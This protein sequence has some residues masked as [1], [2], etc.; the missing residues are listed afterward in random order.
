MHSKPTKWYYSR[1]QMVDKKCGYNTQIHIFQQCRLKKKIMES[2]KAHRHLNP[3]KYQFTAHHEQ[4]GKG[5]QNTDLRSTLA[6]DFHS[7][8]RTARHLSMCLTLCQWELWICLC[9][10]VK[11]SQSTQYFMRLSLMKNHWDLTRKL[12]R[13]STGMKF[14][15]PLFILS[16]QS[17]IFVLISNKLKK[18]KGICLL[19]QPK[20]IKLRLSEWNADVHE[21]PQW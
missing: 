5:E 18:R 11:S 21:G 14:V 4:S 10:F 3:R 6:M 20:A 1:W 12:I 7:R 15:S 19:W 13:S 2:W 17:H 16:E 8:L 9:T